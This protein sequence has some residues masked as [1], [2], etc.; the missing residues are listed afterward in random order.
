MTSYGILLCIFL[1]GGASS[2]QFPPRRIR[3]VQGTPRPQPSVAPAPTPIKPIPARKPSLPN[4]PDEIMGLI[5]ECFSHTQSGYEYQ[6][7]PFKNFTQRELEA[8]NPWSKPFWGM[9]GVFDGMSTD[10][11]ESGDR[12]FT[13]MR[14]EDGDKCGDTPRRASIDIACLTPPPLTGDGNACILDSVSEPETCVYSSML[15]CESVCGAALTVPSGFNPAKAHHSIVDSGDHDLGETTTPAPSSSPSPRA[16]SSAP[17]PS[18]SP[19]SAS[20]SMT[21]AELARAGFSPHTQQPPT[22][23][24]RPPTSGA[25][26]RAADGPAARD[27]ALQASAHGGE[28][29]DVGGE[30]VLA[31]H[32]DSGSTQAVAASAGPGAGTPHAAEAVTPLEALVAMARSLAAAAPRSALA[33][34]AIRALQ[35]WAADAKQGAG[36]E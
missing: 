22:A 30:T 5:G 10:A 28:A 12:V 16:S 24:P 1:M 14:F 9:L 3:I 34:P 18:Q 33:E 29:G 31:G 7:C 27:P 19:A 23:T 26:G 32:G 36:G 21:A 4:G 2:L 15:R 11:A 25:T 8:P 13:G 35:L 6:L 20:V 17:A